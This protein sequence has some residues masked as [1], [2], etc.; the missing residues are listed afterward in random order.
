MNANN[1]NMNSSFTNLS[2]NFATHIESLA[3]QI[4]ENK[5]PAD[6]DTIANIL[7]LL[8]RGFHNS[9][10]AALDNLPQEQ[11]TPEWH[12]ALYQILTSTEQSINYISITLMLYQKLKLNILMMESKY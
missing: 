12:T 2:Q 8:A 10:L 6:R 5:L 7:E 9:T 1:I 11:L 4:R 3:N